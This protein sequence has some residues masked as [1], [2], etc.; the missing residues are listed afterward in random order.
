MEGIPDSGN[1]GI[2]LAQS[3]AVLNLILPNASKQ[4]LELNIKRD[5]HARVLGE[6]DVT[7]SGTDGL[8]FKNIRKSYE[9]TR[10]HFCPSAL[11]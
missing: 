4:F 6:L 5:K 10:L 8:L 1:N 11:G 2:L 7:S 9:T 3:P